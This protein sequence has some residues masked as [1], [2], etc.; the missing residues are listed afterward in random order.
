MLELAS[1]DRGNLFPLNRVGDRLP[2]GR[3]G[4][5]ISGVTAWRW[6]K[7]GLAGVKLETIR[8]GSCR[9]TSIAA[10]T[11]FFERVDAARSIP[12]LC[13][14]V[15]SPLPRTPTQR[16]RDSEKAGQTLDKLRL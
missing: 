9:F 16:Q 3:N 12:E 11:R 8:I 10:L 13:R 2:L 5:P 7:Q 14:P 4:K 6:A 15:G 1:E